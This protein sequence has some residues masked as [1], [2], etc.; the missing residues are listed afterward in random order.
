M[1]RDLLRLPAHT[2]YQ[3]GASVGRFSSAAILA[4][5]PGYPVLVVEEIP[6]YHYVGDGEIELSGLTTVEWGELVVRTWR[7]YAGKDSR[8]S[9]WVDPDTE[10]SKEMQRCKMRLKRNI[11]HG[12]ELRT[13]VTREYFHDNKIFLAPWLTVLPNEIQRA[14]WPPE[15]SSAYKV[16]ATGQDYT[17]SALEQVISRRP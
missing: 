14:R 16:R 6:N 11:G 13:E 15:E 17:L 2:E 12:A 5:L 7:S 4:L 10:F 8:C 3:L 9:A 1:T